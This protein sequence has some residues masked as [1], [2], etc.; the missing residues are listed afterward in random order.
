MD[1]AR[2]WWFLLLKKIHSP[3]EQ[4]YSVNKVIMMS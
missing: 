3:L 2:L 4:I 1:L